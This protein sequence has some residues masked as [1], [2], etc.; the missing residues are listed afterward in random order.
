MHREAPDRLA[1][2][3][4]INTVTP[5][6]AVVLVPLI[7]C[8]EAGLIQNRASNFNRVIAFKSGDELTCDFRVFERCHRRSARPRSAVRS[9]SAYTG[10]L[11]SCRPMDI[12]DD[13]SLEVLRC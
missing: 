10:P 7:V 12:S 1:L 13:F 11:M 3:L 5:Y 8:A 4:K 6:L 2:L 9:L